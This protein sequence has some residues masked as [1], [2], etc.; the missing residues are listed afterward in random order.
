M[1]GLGLRRGEALGLRWRD[2]DLDAANPTLTVNGVIAD[3]L[4]GRPFWTS[5]P[6]TSTSR[7]RLHLP[8]AVTES[9]RRHHARQAQRPARLHRQVG[10]AVAL[11]RL[12]VHHQRRHPDSTPTR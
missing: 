5:M 6:K 1:L 11:R 4:D 2:I 3:D 12:R 8:K 10:T 7:R 9:L